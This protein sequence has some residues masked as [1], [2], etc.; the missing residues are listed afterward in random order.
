LQRFL[1]CVLLGD[2]HMRTDQLGDV[3]VAVDDRV[4]DGAHTLDRSI[5]KYNPEKDFE[6]PFLPNRSR[7]R[8]D[9]ACPV[10]RM[11]AVPERL[12]RHRPLFWIEAE[13]VVHPSRSI[14]ERAT[15]DI[16]GPTTCSA[17][18]LG[19]SQIGLA[20]SQL[21]FR[22][23]YNRH[24]RHRPK[25]LD[26]AGSFPRGVRNGVE[27]FHGAIRHQQSIFMVEILAA[28]GSLFEGPLHGGAIFSV[29][30]LEKK[31]QA[32]FR[33]SVVLQDSERFI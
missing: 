11:N 28:T 5:R 1:C 8:L 15:A 19:F 22:F 13:Y 6:S 27:V 10:F 14:R 2:V 32:R 25:K 20:T 17:Q 33:R 30:A 21:P 7:R 4:P 29:G 18:T 26:V 3:A 16:P 31:L 24:I 12:Q 23:P 9:I